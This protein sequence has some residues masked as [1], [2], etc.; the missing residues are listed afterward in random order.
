MDKKKLLIGDQGKANMNL[1]I[2]FTLTLFYLN[3]RI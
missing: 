2:L 1:K 3:I